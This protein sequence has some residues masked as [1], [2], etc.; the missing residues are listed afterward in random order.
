[1]SVSTL[2]CCSFKN[3]LVHYTIMQNDLASGYKVP[4]R[5]DLIS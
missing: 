1:M 3:L 4:C 2:K 5:N